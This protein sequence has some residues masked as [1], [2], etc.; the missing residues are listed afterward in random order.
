M[1][2]IAESTPCAALGRAFKEGFAA[3]LESF[4]DGLPARPPVT[5]HGVIWKRRLTTEN[6]RSTLFPMNEITPNQPRENLLDTAERLI[7]QSGIHAT[8]IDLLVRTSGVARKSLYRYF[9]TKD[10]LTLE[11]LRRR[12][13]RWMQWYRGEVDQAASSGERLLALFSVLGGWFAS[14]GFRGCA[15]INTAGETGDP[16]DPV[17]Q[18]AKEHKQKLL[19]Y[20][21]ELCEA[22]GIDDPQA[23]G[24]QLLI[25]IDGAITVALVMGDPGAADN[26]QCMARTLL[27]L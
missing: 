2:R 10:D 11:A 12:D 1:R 7:Y 18:L 27:A 6:D 4:A 15:F 23:T 3:N 13:I 21:V 19:D 14:E 17:R 16:K 24:K 8:G 22:H 5:L 26:A 25:L 9:G 20:V